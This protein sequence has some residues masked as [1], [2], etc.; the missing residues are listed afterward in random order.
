MTR[1]QNKIRARTSVSVDGT[2]QS[3]IFRPDVGRLRGGIQLQ[4]IDED[5]QTFHPE[6]LFI[7]TVHEVFNPKS[8]KVTKAQGIYDSSKL[9]NQGCFT[10]TSL[11]LSLI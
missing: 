10:P 1:H 11:D 2:D 9:L 3:S 7:S 6:S 4:H 8:A 5:T